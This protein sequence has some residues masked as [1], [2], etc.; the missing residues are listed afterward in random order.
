MLTNPIFEQFK[1]TNQ[2]FSLEVDRCLRHTK[3]LQNQIELLQEKLFPAK[4][5]ERPPESEAIRM[6]LQINQKIAQKNLLYRRAYEF[7]LLYLKRAD[8]QRIALAQDSA[9]QE[10]VRAKHLK[11]QEQIQKK[12]IKTRNKNSEVRGSSGSLKQRKSTHQNSE[13]RKKN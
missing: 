9:V 13:E 5:K 12:I 7:Q 8:D 10:A 4:K 6:F 11:K 3:A 1:E 2:H